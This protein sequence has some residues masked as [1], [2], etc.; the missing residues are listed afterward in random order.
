MKDSLDETQKNNQPYFFTL[1]GINLYVRY[2]KSTQVINTRNTRREKPNRLTTHQSSAYQPMF[3]AFLHASKY[4]SPLGIT[5][6]L[7]S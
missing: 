3:S 5:D 6:T 4:K 7:F 1:K 2:Y